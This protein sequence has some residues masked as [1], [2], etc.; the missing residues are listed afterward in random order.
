M[1]AL[2]IDSEIL[3]QTDFSWNDHFKELQPQLYFNS[4]LIKNRRTE[5]GMEWKDFHGELFMISLMDT[6]NTLKN[7]VTLR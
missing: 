6:T 5:Y 1:A 2:Q 7:E 3:S 4:S